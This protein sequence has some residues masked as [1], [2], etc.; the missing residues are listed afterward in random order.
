MSPRLPSGRDPQASRRRALPRGAAARRRRPARGAGAAAIAAAVWRATRTLRLSVSPYSRLHMK[1]G[2]VV[3]AQKLGQC[4]NER[5]V[6]I[7][8][9]VGHL[10][11]PLW[12]AVVAVRSSVVP[13]D[14]SPAH[15]LA[16][17]IARS[18]GGKVR[19][20][21]ASAPETGNVP[22]PRAGHPIIAPRRPPDARF[23]SAI[24]ALG[25][26]IGRIPNAN[27]I[28]YHL[29]KNESRASVRLDSGHSASHPTG[30][31]SPMT[32]SPFT[33]GIAS[34][35]LDPEALDQNFRG[36]APAPRR[37]RG[38]CGGGPVLFLPRRTLHHGMS[39]ID[40][41]PAFHPPDR[42]RHARGGGEDHLRPEHPRRHVR[43]RLPHRNALRRGLRA[44]DG[45]G[46]AGGDR[47]AAALRH[48]HRDG[49]GRSPLPARRA[50]GQDRRRD[51]RGAR[52]AC[53]RAPARHAWP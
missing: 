9:F 48:R 41:H 25:R 14:A 17:Y 10:S 37:P 31:R 19:P 52:G 46:Q 49:S 21:K 26:C 29:I 35:R 1:L 11:S 7:V 30:T 18:A 39:H 28:I 50:H 27:R 36:P 43:A 32:N 51:R 38:A 15:D 20:C 13:E 8:S 24:P 12:F 44:R 5:H 23:F 47:P 22:G 4:L 2:Q 34:A 3:F 33:P 45:G 6:L 16:P 53:L 40:R 42:D